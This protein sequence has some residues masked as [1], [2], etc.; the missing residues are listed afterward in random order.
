MGIRWS[1]R[2]CDGDV[3]VSSPSRF[4]IIQGAGHYTLLDQGRAIHREAREDILKKFASDLV[5]AEEL[6]GKVRS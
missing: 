3:Q 2:F 6:E 1:A 5:A 4:H